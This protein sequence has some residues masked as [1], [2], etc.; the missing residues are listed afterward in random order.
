MTNYTYGFDDY[1][2]VVRE[3]RMTIAWVAILVLA[4]TVVFTAVQGDPSAATVVSNV[5][6]AVVA[7][8]LEPSA[9]SDETIQPAVERVKALSTEVLADAARS[10]PGAPEPD[11]IAEGLDVVAHSDTNT[12]LFHSEPINEVDGFDVSEAVA[13]SY[14]MQRRREID[15]ALAIAQESL[16][17]QLRMARELGGSSV[18]VSVQASTLT[19]E[20]A[21]LT[22][23]RRS[24]SG[25]E[26]VSSPVP[27]AELFPGPTPPPGS[28][29]PAVDENGHKQFVRNGIAG[30]VLGLILGFGLALAMDLL[31]PRFRSIEEVRSVLPVPLL[32]EIAG[33]PRDARREAIEETA[34]QLQNMTPSDDPGDLTF[35]LVGRDKRESSEEELAQLHDSLASLKPTLTTSLASAAGTRS[36]VIVL[37][38]STSTRQ[39]ARR[40]LQVLERSGVTTLGTLLLV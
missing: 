29:A 1:I 13:T 2:R 18:F 40:V 30:L 14:L 27:F 19:R 8:R 5:E 10:I 9:V 15:E 12:L 24:S 38:K 28:V 3:R 25:G 17:R 33:D 39:E 23:L 4:S 7:V 35:L 32:A 11:V 36:V 26:I 20:I 31:D 34:V 21:R 22:S 16:R 37:I 6:T